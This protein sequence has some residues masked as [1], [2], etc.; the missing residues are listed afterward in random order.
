MLKIKDLRI[1]S[2]QKTILSCSNIAIDKG[3]FV[4]VIGPSGVGKSTFLNYLAGFIPRKNIKSMQLGNI[5]NLHANGVVT[6]DDH[7]ITNFPASERDIAVL[8]QQDNVYPHMTVF[9]NICF[10]LK[11]KNKSKDEQVKISEDLMDV[12]RLDKSKISQ[13]AKSLSGGE[14]QRLALAKM[15]ARSASMFLLDEP[16]SHLDPILREYLRGQLVERL[17][18][19][20][21]KI[22]VTH[23]WDDLKVADKVVLIT[24]AKDA[25]DNVLVIT[26]NEIMQGNVDLQTCNA[27]QVEWVEAVSKC[28]SSD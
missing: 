18:G 27:D 15:L 9:E 26:K 24:S 22:L 25:E 16:F 14:K 3:Q 20:E 13:R 1:S 19:D 5:K 23:D 6:V 2:Q 21:I 10:P 11:R 17:S 12:V 8:Y 28:V 7:D 4:A